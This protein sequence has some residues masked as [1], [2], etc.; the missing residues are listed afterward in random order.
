M[1][2][3]GNSGTSRKSSAAKQ[4]LRARCAKTGALRRQQLTASQHEREI[5]NRALRKTG[6][7]T[8]W[9]QSCAFRAARREA[10]GLREKWL[11]SRKSEQLP[12]S[13]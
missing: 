6:D 4:A 13:G 2:G 1:M 8:L 5:A 11:K 12:A 3:T 9:E 7:L 10:A